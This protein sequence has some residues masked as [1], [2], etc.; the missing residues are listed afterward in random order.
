[1]N[2]REIA[3]GYRLTHWAGI[4]RERQESGLSIREFCKNAGYRENV[5]YYWQKRLR[6]AAC[7]EL[8]PAARRVEQE[9]SAPAG[10]VTCEQAEVKAPPLAVE[11]GPYRVVV[12]KGADAEQIANVCRALA[13]IC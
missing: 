5:Y 12:E 1:V 7:K 2:T 13:S 6:E 3:A 9:P 10:W 4:M 8:V 11:I